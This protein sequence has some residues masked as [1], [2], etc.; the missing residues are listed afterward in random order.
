MPS[1]WLALP[2]TVAAAIA[3]GCG[4]PS[5]AGRRGAEG[6][7]P[8]HRADDPRWSPADPPPGPAPSAASVELPAVRGGCPIPARYGG[9]L[10][11]GIPFAPGLALDLAVPAGP[12]PHPW[13]V[14]LHGGGWNAGERA[15]VRHEIRILA[16]LGYAGAAVD[17]RLVGPRGEHAFPAAAAD[18]RCAIRHLRRAAARY[19]LDPGRSAAF[20]LSAGGHLALVAAL[21]SDRSD[22]D[23]GSCP[24]RATSPAVQAVLALYGPADLRRRDGYGAY[25]NRVIDA[26]LGGPERRLA[27]LASPISL[28]S[29][30]DPPTFLAH[31]ALDEVVPVDESR[32]LR[33]ALQRAGVPVRYVEEPTQGHSFLLFDRTPE[34]PR[35]TCTALAFL[36][37][38]IGGR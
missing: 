25:A 29:S 5:D 35:V 19:R 30:D 24:D 6:E 23:D 37:R 8:P 38:T 18:A 12:G 31:G 32:R 16:A 13:V 22:L 14:V 36:A 10:R 33:T 20:G 15:H 3:L 2:A 9:E 17:Y 34:L 11:L 21:G 28:V 27:A 4:A 7:P 1:P 26:L